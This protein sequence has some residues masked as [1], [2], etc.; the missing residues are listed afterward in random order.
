MATKKK[1]AP[2]KEAPAKKEAAKP[3]GDDWYSQGDV[4]MQK[5]RSQD[6]LSAA[7]K[8]RGTSRFFLKEREEALVTFVGDDKGFFIWE[9]NLKINGKW[10]NFVTCTKE[11]KPCPV[12]EAGHKPTYTAYYTVID[13]REFELKQGPNAGKKIKNRKLLYP[14]KGSTMTVLSDLK[15]SIKT[16]SGKTFLVKRLSSEDPNCGRDFTAK[17]T[18]NAAQWKALASAA[19]QTEAELKSD[20]EY[21]KILSPMSD[22]ELA[23]L[24]FGSTVLGAQEEIQSASGTGLSDLVNI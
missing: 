16:V 3:I 20:I 10:G 14:A 15:K 22:E 5:K 12:C 17:G 21:K 9:H 1:E 4:G 13:H 8:E 2:A 11:W 7:R 6:A 19:K 24:G 18:L 23:A